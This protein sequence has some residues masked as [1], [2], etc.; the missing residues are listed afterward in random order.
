M[1]WRADRVAF[2]EVLALREA[3][4]CPEPLAWTLVR[5]GLGDPAAA[6]EFMANDGPLADP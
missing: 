5:R 2:A 4:D 6:R 1:G 3:L